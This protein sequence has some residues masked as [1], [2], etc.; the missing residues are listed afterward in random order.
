M[1]GHGQAQLWLANERI[2]ERIAEAAR[3]RR[4]ARNERPSLRRSL[5]KSMIALGQRLAADA[6][7]HGP[8]A[9]KAFA[10]RPE[11]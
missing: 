2:R 4:V 10:P 3:A 5:G 7:S 1:H 9:G 6:S 8:A 11:L